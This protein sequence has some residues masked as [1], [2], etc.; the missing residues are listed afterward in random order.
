M[1]ATS[2][3][4]FSRLVTLYSG[5]NATT[6][7]YS[8][9]QYQKVW[10]IIP[11]AAGTAPTGTIQLEASGSITIQDLARGLVTA[12]KPQSVTVSAGTVYLVLV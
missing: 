9:S 6:C 11:A 8:G 10:G 2:I 7:N 5:S 4:S 3:E 12:L 1:A